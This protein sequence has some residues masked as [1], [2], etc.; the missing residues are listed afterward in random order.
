MPPISAGA[1]IV[2]VYTRGP[3]A[4]LAPGW[5]SRH[6]I[7]AVSGSVHELDH[8]IGADP[9]DRAVPPSLKRGKG[10]LS[11]PSETNH[12]RRA[13]RTG[14][15]FRRGRSAKAKLPQ[16]I[17][18]A[19]VVLFLELVFRRA[20]RGIAAQPELLDKALSLSVGLQASE[21]ARSRSSMRY[22]TSPFSHLS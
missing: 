11:R 8:H 17:R 18:D 21:S 16:G 2:L 7:V 10:W 20:G 14:Y 9:M 5:V 15:R 4:I 1:L 19:A 22:T 13:D 12:A 6:A 3:Q